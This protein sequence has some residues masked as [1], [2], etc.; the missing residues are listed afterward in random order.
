MQNVRA[1]G[2]ILPFTLLLASP[3]LVLAVLSTSHGFNHLRAR[4]HALLRSRTDSLLRLNVKPLVDKLASRILEGDST[5]ALIEL[6]PDVPE[7]LRPILLNPEG[8]RIPLHSES[9]PGTMPT[10]RFASPLS[11]MDLAAET[12]PLSPDGHPEQFTIAW[13]AEDIALAAP[14][15][16]PWPAWPL[17]SWFMAPGRTDLTLP[18]LLGAETLAVLSAGS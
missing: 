5:S 6:D 12:I 13:A 17:E 7:S 14:Q 15:A 8:S 18:G 3:I 11:D 1:S 2:F 9:A 4:E 16:A 10:V